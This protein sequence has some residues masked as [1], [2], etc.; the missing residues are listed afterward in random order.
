M[1]FTEKLDIL[2]KSRGMTRGSLAQKTGIPYNTIMGFYNKGYKNS[3]LS[4]MRKISELFG[5]SLDVLCD[6]DRELYE[7]QRSDEQKELIKKYSALSEKGRDIV[8]GVIDGLQD[9]EAGQTRKAKIT[10]IEYIREYVTP[11]AAGYASPAE[12]DDY[13]L[14]PKTEDTPKAADFA[15][16]IVGDSMEP[17][18]A[19]GSRVYVSR[20]S[21]LEPGD[22]GI[23]FVDGDMKCKQYCEDNEGNIYLFSANRARSDADVAVM[24]SSGVTVVCFGKVLLNKRIPLPKQ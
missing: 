2:M 17:Y 7:Q 20:M 8:D 15:V 3:R 1:E 11:A 14:V 22:V 10:P 13:I 23:F 6:D 21:G 16:R 12:G 9:I 19:D 24:A 18:I 5:V 4:N